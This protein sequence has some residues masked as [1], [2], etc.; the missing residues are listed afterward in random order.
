ME[1]RSLVNKEMTLTGMVGQVREAE[2][3]STTFIMKEIE[4]YQEKGK[5]KIEGK[6]LL[7]ADNYPKYKYGDRLSFKGILEYPLVYKYF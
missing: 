5:K 3:P 6:I 7:V 4:Y 2:G 1:L